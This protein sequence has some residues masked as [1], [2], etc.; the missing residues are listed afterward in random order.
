VQ[1]P[2]QTQLKII[3][4]PVLLEVSVQQAP[5]HAQLALQ[6]HLLMLL[7]TTVILELQEASVVQELA[8]EQLD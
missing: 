3:V 6:G 5:H 7:R 4:I 2:T 1:V 8:D